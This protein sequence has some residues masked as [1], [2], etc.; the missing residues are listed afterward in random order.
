MAVAGKDIAVGFELPPYN[1]T[2]TMPMMVAMSGDNPIHWD[3]ELSKQEGLKT[4]IATGMINTGWLSHMLMEFFG[5][6]W[7]VSGQIKNVYVAQVFEHDVVTSR[8]VVKGKNQE[9]GGTRV[10]MDA[11][12]E[13][14]KGEKVTAGKASVLVRK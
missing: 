8:A 2:V 7:V 5:E 4:A 10:V 14:Q 6:D 11:W 12:C 3:E 13:N 9:P 1:R